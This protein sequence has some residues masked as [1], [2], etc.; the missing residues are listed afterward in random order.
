MKKL[1]KTIDCEM[2]PRQNNNNLS[3]FVLKQF[4]VGTFM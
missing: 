1:I 4:M 3:V 2:V